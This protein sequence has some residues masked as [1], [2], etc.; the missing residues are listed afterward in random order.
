M[1]YSVVLKRDGSPPS[2]GS[3]FAGD[4]FRSFSEGDTPPRRAALAQIAVDN[5]GSGPWTIFEVA[6]Q[7]EHRQIVGIEY[8]IEIALRNAADALKLANYAG[9]RRKERILRQ[10]AQIT[11]ILLANGESEGFTNA[12]LKAFEE[13]ILGG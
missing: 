12:E 8:A 10:S 9:F 2:V 3:T 1:A 5:I 13:I 6:D 11:N 7:A 4:W